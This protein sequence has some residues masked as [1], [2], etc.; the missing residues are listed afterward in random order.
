[1]PIRKA[2]LTTAAAAL[3]SGLYAT[4]AD[5]EV[6]VGTTITG[7][8]T[9]DTDTDGAGT[10]DSLDVTGVAWTSNGVTAPSSTL[11]FTGTATNFLV[12]GASANFIN[13]NTNIGSG[14][15]WATSVDLVLDANTEIELTQFELNWV[16]TNN[17]GAAQNSG[18]TAQWTV[19]IVGSTSGSLGPITLSDTGA[20]ALGNNELLFN[21][22][23]F[24][25]L[26]TSETYTLNLSVVEQPG[27]NG[28]FARLEDFELTGD[29][30]VVPEPGSLALMG[31]GGLLCLKR[32]RR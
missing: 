23:T 14:G 11:A 19:D 2:L 6:I 1:M 16:A 13:P 15:T 5:A 26:N 9:T 27:Q 8:N 21:L 22:T 17:S 4:Q 31:I 20:T 12:G 28:F 10:L 30:T 18:R 24:A 3:V 25:T 29:I 32:R 7:V